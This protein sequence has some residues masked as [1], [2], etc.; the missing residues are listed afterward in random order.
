MRLWCGGCRNLRF[1]GSTLSGAF[2]DFD[3]HIKGCPEDLS[4]CVAQSPKIGIILFY[5]RRNHL[6]RKIDR[7]TRGHRSGQIYGVCTHRV[8]ADI[9]EPV[10]RSP[11]AGANVFDPPGLGECGARR[12]LGVVDNIQVSQE[13]RII[14]G[15][16]RPQV[17]YGY[18]YG[19]VEEIVC[20]GTIVITVG[21]G[22]EV[23]VSGVAEGATVK[24][25]RFAS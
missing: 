15:A 2:A 4:G 24:V 23:G 11:C 22:V 13:G 1:G 10:L 16:W 9:L 14:A 19:G 5:I 21:E 8:A 6:Q 12:Y 17:I 25:G 20:V 7:F 3:R 18:G